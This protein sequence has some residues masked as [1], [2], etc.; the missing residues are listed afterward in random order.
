MLISAPKTSI[1]HQI[2][3]VKTRHL[4]LTFEINKA[5]KFAN[6][7]LSDVINAL[8]CVYLFLFAGER[9]GYHQ[10]NELQSSFANCFFLRKAVKM[11]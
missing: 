3:L 6:Q 10:R 2:T 1:N 7:L 5:K 9:I 8:A 4:L 11:K